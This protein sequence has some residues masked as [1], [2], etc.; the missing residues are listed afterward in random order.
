M[1][2]ASLTLPEAL[3]IEVPQRA[4]RIV[5]EIN[6]TNFPALYGEIIP[7]LYTKDVRVVST[8]KLKRNFIDN[9]ENSLH[10]ILLEE[11][12][13][14]GGLEEVRVSDLTT[15]VDSPGQPIL[16]SD[17]YMQRLTSSGGA[18]ERDYLLAR[19]LLH[20]NMHRGHVPVDIA[21]KPGEPLFNIA[22]ASARLTDANL[23]PEERT[24]KELM[25]VAAE[26]SDLMVRISGAEISLFCSSS[27][28]ARFKKL[29]SSGYDLN[30]AIVEMLILDQLETLLQ[31]VRKNHPIRLQGIEKPLSTVGA[32]SSAKT[33]RYEAKVY[34]YFE[35]L[36]IF[37]F[38]EAYPAFMQGKIPL[39]HVEKLADSE[40]FF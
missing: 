30:E 25:E 22:F 33:H 29:I 32:G 37:G 23:N 17:K 10:P 36:G 18:V 12:A 4:I 27:T 8:D 3:R 11:L 14:N 26:A 19:A 2:E 38:E 24:S 6:K 9:A 28:D 34:E 7:E 40:Y 16:I 13:K 5:N 1:L 39:L 35:Q 15:F 20:E 21:V 31:D